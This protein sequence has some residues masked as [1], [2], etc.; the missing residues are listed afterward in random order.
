VLL[1]P[2]LAGPAAALAAP[3]SASG[4]E[5]EI[6]LKGAHSRTVEPRKALPSRIGA[7]S[8]SRPLAGGLP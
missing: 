6:D 4:T 5:L 8:R 7:V 2:F 3:P 1:A